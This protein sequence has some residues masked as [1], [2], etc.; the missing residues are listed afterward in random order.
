MTNAL[1]FRREITWTAPI[2]PTPTAT[3]PSCSGP[4]QDH[5]S[6]KV[7][8]AW[9][10]ALDLLWL[11]LSALGVVAFVVPEHAVEAVA[12]LDV[13]PA[14]D[15]G[16]GEDRPMTFLLMRT[17]SVFL[18]MVAS[19]VPCAWSASARC[20]SALSMLLAT[21]FWIVVLAEDEFVVVE[22]W[23]GV[24]FMVVLSTG[25]VY[26]AGDAARLLRRRLRL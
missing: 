26:L 21:I 3:E 22:E 10:S 24:A 18:L 16:S 9:K 2:Q 6:S 11:L 14:D 19:S 13:A 12:K 20:L 5:L 4:V 17:Y 25:L 1:G 15:P 23:F 8:L 7:A